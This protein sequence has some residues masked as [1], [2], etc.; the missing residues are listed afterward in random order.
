MKILRF[1]KE[2]SHRW[3]VDLPEW[4]GAK[5]DLEM[6][7]GAD[8]MCDIIAQGEGE[9]TL[10]L[11]L[12]MFKNADTLE[13][14]READEIG[15]GAFYLFK[16]YRGLDLDLVIWLCDVTKFVFGDFPKIIYLQS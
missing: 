4:Q 6:V 13:F 9:I 16:S 3:Y 1:Y 14:I 10:S 8:T 5:A 7:G 12:E 15:E 11:S 2:E